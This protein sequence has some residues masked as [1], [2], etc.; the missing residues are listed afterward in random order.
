VAFFTNYLILQLGDSDAEWA[1]SL[2]FGEYNWRWMLGLEAIPAILY[3]FALFFVPRSP[4]WLAMKGNYDEAMTI[5]CK[6]LDEKEAKKIIDDVKNSFSE[7]KE[8]KRSFKDLFHP[9]LRFVLVIGVVIGILQQITGINSVFF[10]APMIFEQSGIGTDASF[11]QAILVGLI[12]LAFTVLAISLIDK[13][14][15]KPLLVF[16]VSGMAIALF[17]L[18]YGF[19]SATYEL[20]EDSVQGITADVDKEL[21]A[22]YIGKVYEDDLAFKTDMSEAIGDLE[23]KKYESQFLTAAVDMNAVLILVGILG[24]VASF[25][26]SLG[27]VMWV[28]FSELFPNWI[29]GLAISFVGLINSAISFLVQVVFPWELEVLG[30]STTFFIYG[31]FALLGVVFIIL[32][33]PETKGKSLEELEA[34]LVK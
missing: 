23:F 4:R 25:A 14:G 32:K 34:I 9:S 26:V 31:F 7:K 19:S 6:A 3:F 27:P 21:L 17:L 18:A 30:S 20:S 12:N 2:K 10:Y 29:R 15:R 22:P 33:V 11:S 28:L 16:G 8:E 5:M 24:F 1:K 13:L